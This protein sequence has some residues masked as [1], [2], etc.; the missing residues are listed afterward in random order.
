M[1][2]LILIATFTGEHI[3][4]DHSELYFK[5]FVAIFRV[6]PYTDASALCNK[7]VE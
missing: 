5:N 1:K 4:S 6:T 3:T 2:Q 7:D